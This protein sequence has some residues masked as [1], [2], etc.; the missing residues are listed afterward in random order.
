MM[1]YTFSVL[2]EYD[3]HHSNSN[4]IIK[5]VYYNLHDC[6]VLFWMMDPSLFCI[7][8]IVNNIFLPLYFFS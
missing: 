5:V 7:S 4:R 2:T 1:A 8:A 6:F 3:Y